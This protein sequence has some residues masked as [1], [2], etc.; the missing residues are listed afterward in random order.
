M[1]FPFVCDMCN[2]T[3]WS[4]RYNSEDK[5]H[6]ISCSGCSKTVILECIFGGRKVA[7]EIKKKVPHSTGSV[8]GAAESGVP[9]NG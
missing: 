5:C 2:G 9:K 6:Q 7:D 3:K 4:I 1:L 8:V